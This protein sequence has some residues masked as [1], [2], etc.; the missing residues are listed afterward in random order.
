MFI[1]QVTLK[2]KDNSAPGFTTIVEKNVLPLLNKQSGF[3]DAV[4]FV[5]TDRSE[6][7]CY[8]F[9]NTNEE[10]EVY[11]KAGNLEVLKALT[12]ITEGTPQIQDFS[13]SNST[14]HKVDVMR[15]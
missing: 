1:H 9:W 13:L 11:N 10:A 5:S 2:L 12:N 8:T 15:V 7:I 4:T 3:R 6:A 14:F